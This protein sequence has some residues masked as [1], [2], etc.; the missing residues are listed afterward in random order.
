[1]QPFVSVHALF[2]PRQNVMPRGHSLPPLSP[3]L[4]L[5]FTCLFRL[6]PAS[7][8]PHSRRFA[9]AFPAS[10]TRL[11]CP[12][13]VTLLLPFCCLFTAL[14][15]RIFRLGATSLLAPHSP[16]SRRFC[17]HLP[18]PGFDF[19]QRPQ[20]EHIHQRR[21]PYAQI[22]RQRADLLYHAGVKLVGA[23][24][25]ARCSHRPCKVRYCHVPALSTGV[26]PHTE[27]KPPISTFL[28]IPRA[29]WHRSGAGCGAAHPAPPL[30]CYA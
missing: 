30:C 4:N 14:R 17:P 16:I 21:G 29:A 10:S 13:P 6:S 25:P 7:V 23:R 8:Q 18:A 22:V 28:N 26:K 5:P 27:K 9:R 20:Q 11:H 19:T 2:Q 12:F 1:M 24:L 15:F 3:V